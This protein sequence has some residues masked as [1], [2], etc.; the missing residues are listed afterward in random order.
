[1]GTG[2]WEKPRLAHRQGEE[3]DLSTPPPGFRRS[4][5]SFANHPAPDGHLSPARLQLQV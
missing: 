3:K 5:G 4:W 1:M 2:E